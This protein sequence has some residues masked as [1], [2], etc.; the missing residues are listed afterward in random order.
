M[1]ILKRTITGPT[2]VLAAIV[3]AAPLGAHGADAPAQKTF[4]QPEAAV[5]ALLAAVSSGN[6]TEQMAILGPGSE[7]IV[8]SG[9]PVADKIAAQRIA[10]AAAERTRVE[11][12]GSGD[13]VA[14]LGKDDW[15]LPIP[16]V[17]DGERWRFDTVAAHDEVLNRRIGRNELKAIQVSR[18]YV[19]AQREYASRDRG[20]G[21]GVYA[22]KLRS[23]PGKQDGLYW[24]DE[25][26]THP[27]PLGPLL[28]EAS[29][30]GY[31]PR[32]EGA[33]P[34]PYHG[35]LYRSLQAQGASAPGGARSYVKDGKMTGGFA[36]LAIPAE[37][38]SSG[39]MT[40]MVGP[41]GIVYQKNLGDKTAE[42][43]KAITTFDPDD[44]WTPVRD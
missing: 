21:A 17:K 40:F 29:A 22:Q 34:Q 3:L 35:Y 9:D 10:K 12:L 18:A 8:S 4:A 41:Q 19:D 14:Y 33:A 2:A 28:A 24:N 36:L 13:V 38:G 32:Q 5:R 26:G 15:P 31:G 20:A 6:K 7:D 27:S 43:A 11:T 30:E 23:E 42:A 1:R 44:S 37:H 16:L 39:I 25:S